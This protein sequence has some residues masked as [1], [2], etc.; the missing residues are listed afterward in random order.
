MYGI[1]DALNKNYGWANKNNNDTVFC[2]IIK[3]NLLLKKL[4]ILIVY[5]S[6]IFY[7]NTFSYIYPLSAKETLLDYTELFTGTATISSTNIY[8]FIS[9]LDS[10]DISAHIF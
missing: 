6:I 7:S 3:R 10:V 9:V 4:T 5:S 1:Y 8:S 2:F